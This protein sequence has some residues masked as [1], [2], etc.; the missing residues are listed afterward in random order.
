MSVP[1]VEGSRGPLVETVHRGD[2]A[3]VDADGRS[4]FSAGEPLAKRAFMRSSAKPLQA[5]PIVYTGAAERWGFDDAD[6]AIFCASHN[7]EP[8]H[9]ERVERVLGRIG[10]GPE[11]LRC[12]VH[13]PLDAVRAREMRA[14]GEAPTVLH[15]NCSGKHAGMLALALHLGADPSGYLEPGHPVQR[16]VIANVAR[17]AGVEPADI[18]LGVDGCGVP[19]FGITVFEAALAFA[20]LANPGSLGE[21]YRAAAVR[22]R[23]AMRSNPYLIA[24][25]G[26]FDTDVMTTARGRVV[27]KGGASGVHCI[28]VDGGTGVAVKIE[29]GG[30]PP[31][32]QAAVAAIEALRQL[33]TL[34]GAALAALGHHARP[35]IRN[36]AGRDVGGARPVFTLIASD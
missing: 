33:G 6:L 16:E 26:R 19:C 7:G 10:L 21:P 32:S 15:S 25:R 27:S 24:G 23:D 35:V 11:H 12:G 2:L 30:S 34:D 22:V 28:A 29:D 20:R 13:P 14:A 36:V 5:M 31:Y 4:R 1:L 18:A 17:M 9:T 8:V 3:V